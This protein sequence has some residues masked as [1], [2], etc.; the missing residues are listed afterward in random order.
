MGGIIQ[1]IASNG[2]R[3]A[4]FLFKFRIWFTT[5]TN[6]GTV[7]NFIRIINNAFGQVMTAQFYCS[8]SSPPK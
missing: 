2:W 4:F 5:V 8:D 1:N 3:C 6:A 7:V